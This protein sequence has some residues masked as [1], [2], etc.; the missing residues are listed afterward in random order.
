MVIKFSNGI[1]SGKKVGILHAAGDGVDLEV[2]GTTVLGGD[3]A[4]E[5]RQP[6]DVAKLLGVP[7]ASPEALRDFFS[8]L[9][10]DKP[11]RPE[12][13]QQAVE[14]SSFGKH[15]A[16]AAHMATIVRTVVD[17]GPKLVDLVRHL[18]G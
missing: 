10:A 12:E 15:V 11:S 14:K 16:S 4:V 8:R 13:V 1:I 9:P 7:E 5:I 18:I 2:D 17:A 6:V 3:A